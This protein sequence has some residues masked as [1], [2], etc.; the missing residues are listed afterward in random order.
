MQRPETRPQARR[1]P[2]PGAATA[3]VANS[4]PIRDVL[5]TRDMFVS[6]DSLQA[7]QVGGWKES[8][9]GSDADQNGVVRGRRRERRLSIAM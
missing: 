3:S 2:I 6:R 8:P 4:S 5:R 1:E 7:G 9:G